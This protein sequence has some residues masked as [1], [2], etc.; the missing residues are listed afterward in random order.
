MIKLCKK[1]RMKVKVKCNSPLLQ[2]TL[3]YY[4]KKYLDENGV[5][6][7]DD[8]EKDGI[9]IGKDIKKPFT[10]SSL[11]LQLEK[12]IKKTSLEEE[13]DK[14]CEEFKTKL[15]HLIKDYL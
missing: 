12:L 3:E 13:I 14:L 10:K 6:I 11:L 8:F 2:K 15:K 4:L 1:V 5:L 9:I 7:T